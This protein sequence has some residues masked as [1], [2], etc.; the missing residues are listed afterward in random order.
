MGDDEDNEAG[1]MA[2]QSPFSPM[3]GG[4]PFS[5]PSPG[6]RSSPMTSAYSPATPADTSQFRSP[7]Y[8]PA[9]ES[10]DGINSPA[11]SEFSQ[12]YPYSA[13]P[14]YTPDA[15][16]YASS[17]LGETTS[18]PSYAAAAYSPTFSPSHTPFGAHYGSPGTSMYSPAPTSPYDP[19]GAL[20]PTS[21]AD[22]PVAYSPG[23]PEADEFMS[24]A[25]MS[26]GEARAPITSGS[27]IVQEFYQAPASPTDRVAPTSPSYTPHAPPAVRQAARFAEPAVDETEFVD[28]ADSD[29]DAMS[30]L[31]EPADD[32]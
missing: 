21:P 32:Y 23:S 12:S 29:D 18:S 7:S 14:A 19:T 31:F 15:S 27:P 30:T 11:M 16:G 5:Q 8:T 17:R 9:S 26:P 10:P 2:G 13:S 28:A 4:T 25:L 6:A 20:D 24:P 22:T 1:L 3:G